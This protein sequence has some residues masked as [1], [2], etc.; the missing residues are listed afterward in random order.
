MEGPGRRGCCGGAAFD[1]A[2]VSGVLCGVLR[3][4]DGEATLTPTELA[5]RA[6]GEL[7]VRNSSPNAEASLEVWGKPQTKPE[8]YYEL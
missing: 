4:V 2:D 1:R 8:E 5:P 3:P 7:K 6:G